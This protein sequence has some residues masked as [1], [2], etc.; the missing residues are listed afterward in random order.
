MRLDPKDAFA[1]QN[2]GSAYLALNR[3]DEAKSIAEQAVAQKL[4]GNGV[5]TILAD[6]AYIRGDWTAYNHQMEGERGTQDEPFMLFWESRRP[7]RE[8]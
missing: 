1:Y 6:V 7:R 8:G 4:D 2:L 5:H 3:F